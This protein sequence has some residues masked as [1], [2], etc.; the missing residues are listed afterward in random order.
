M[1]KNLYS[2]KREILDALSSAMEL[3]CMENGYANFSEI[4]E[5]A[6]IS[7]NP[8]TYA[9]VEYIALRDEYRI[10]KVGRGKRVIDKIWDFPE[11]DNKNE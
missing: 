1:K 9:I 8:E 6:Q 3:L 11:G 2:K 10:E 7:G 5:L 4:T